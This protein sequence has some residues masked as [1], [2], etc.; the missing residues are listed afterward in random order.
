MV[1][2]QILHLLPFLSLSTG[3]LV[4]IKHLFMNFINMQS[5]RIKYNTLIKNIHDGGLNFPDIQTIYTTVKARWTIRI[6]SKE[7]LLSPLPEIS[8]ATRLPQHHLPSFLLNAS[9]IPAPIHTINTYIKD[10]ICSLY[11]LRSLTQPPKNPMK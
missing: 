1:I 7:S 8:R 9:Q 11:K 2:S 4:E 6:T 10:N 3:Q 5:I